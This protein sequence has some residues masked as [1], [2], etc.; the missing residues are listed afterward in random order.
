MCHYFITATDTDA[1]KT[2]IS[3]ML[4]QTAKQSGLKCI[5]FKPIASGSEV[6]PEGLRNDDALKIQSANSIALTYEQFNPYS[7]V[8]AIAPHIAAQQAGISISID[9]ITALYKAIVADHQPDFSL[10]EA[11]GGWEVPL[12][13][14]FG[15]PDLAKSVSLPIIVVVKIKLGCINHALLTLKAIQAE[16][17]EIKGWIANDVLDDAITRQN[18]AAIE[19]RTYVPLLA[20]ITH[21]HEQSANESQRRQEFEDL[22][23]AIV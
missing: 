17:L 9:K 3:S 7:F 16:G 22:L 19:K 6:T 11:V 4:L 23:A 8:P 13:D 21:W 20:R 14:N 2:Y 12:D 10:L 18:I 5:G 1:G 15:I